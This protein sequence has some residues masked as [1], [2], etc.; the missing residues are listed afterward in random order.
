MRTAL[1]I[2]ALA[3]IMMVMELGL[4]QGYFTPSLPISLGN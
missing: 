2:I 4:I 1:G 3:L